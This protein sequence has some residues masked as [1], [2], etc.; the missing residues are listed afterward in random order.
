MFLQNFA[1]KTSYKCSWG[2]SFQKQHL[3]TALWCAAETC[4]Q[5]QAVKVMISNL[6]FF[7]CFCTFT[8]DLHQSLMYHLPKHT[9]T[10]SH[11]L[12]LKWPD[13]FIACSVQLPNRSM[14][15]LIYK[16]GFGGNEVYRTIGLTIC[17]RAL[18]HCIC[19]TGQIQST[20]TKKSFSCLTK[21]INVW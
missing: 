12:W 9:F 1:N 8:I 20:V 3:M 10:T 14:K 21:I 13:H 4:V 11:T 18:L 2:N 17:F 15:M 16:R 19:Y 5:L 7:Y 6:N